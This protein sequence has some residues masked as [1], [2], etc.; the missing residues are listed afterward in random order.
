[1]VCILPESLLKSWPLEKNHSEKEKK[2]ETDKKTKM[3]DRNFLVEYY[4]GFLVLVDDF[5]KTPISPS[6]VPNIY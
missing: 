5:K 2:W 3:S 1:M 4:S 6:Y